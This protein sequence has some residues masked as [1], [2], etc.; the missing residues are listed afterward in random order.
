MSPQTKR[1]LENIEHRRFKWK[2][3][4]SLKNINYLE[5]ETSDNDQFSFNKEFK[6]AFEDE[7]IVGKV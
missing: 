1:F 7:F 5:Q 2:N 3:K 4:R 6:K